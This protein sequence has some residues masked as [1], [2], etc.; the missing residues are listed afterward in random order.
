M[1]D[2]VGQSCMDAPC[3]LFLAVPI[4]PLIGLRNS[5]VRFSPRLSHYEAERGSSTSTFVSNVYDT[6]SMSSTFTSPV[7]EDLKR[8]PSQRR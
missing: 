2:S 6:S 7:D 4:P 1:V 8:L 5:V 3:R